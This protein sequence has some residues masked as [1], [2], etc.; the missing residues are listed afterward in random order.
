MFS[1]QP[2]FRL[3]SALLNAWHVKTRMLC[4][5]VAV[6]WFHLLRAWLLSVWLWCGLKCSRVCMGPS[7]VQMSD[8]QM[9][10]GKRAASER[11]VHGWWPRASLMWG[12]VVWDVRRKPRKARM[13]TG[14]FHFSV[15]LWALLVLCI[16]VYF[17]LKKR[18]FRCW[19][20]HHN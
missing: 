16:T 15:L 1:I 19:D 10:W 11:R 6:A 12:S 2:L 7:G 18:I 5:C 8:R 9:A 20:S 4:T 13:Q 14:F 17:F 3:S